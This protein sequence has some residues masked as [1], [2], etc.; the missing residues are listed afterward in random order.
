M[1]LENITIIILGLMLSI[2]VYNDYIIPFIIGTP[3][4]NM[5]EE[6]T[7]Q[8]SSLASLYI[9][10]QLGLSETYDLSKPEHASLII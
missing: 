2:Y 6:F 10:E 4:S 1:D 3:A 8:Y 5:L 9:I 7:S